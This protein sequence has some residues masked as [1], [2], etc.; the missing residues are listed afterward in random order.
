MKKQLGS[1][2]IEFAFTF[3]LFILLLGVTFETM[4]YTFI[5]AF[6]DYTLSVSSKWAKNSF[7]FDHVNDARYQAEFQR[8]IE[9]SDDFRQSI[10]NRLF[11]NVA[12]IRYRVTPVE[13]SS[14]NNG[15][16][17][18]LVYY[19]IEYPFRVWLPGVRPIKISS[20]VAMIQEYSRFER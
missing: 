13:I 19:S 3:P 10:W 20:S 12:N 2:T 4:R 9:D 1:T 18:V 17:S 11:I 5:S 16:S 6:V 15:S 8:R 14:F 7:Y